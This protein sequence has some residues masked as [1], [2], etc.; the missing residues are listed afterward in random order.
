MRG[1]KFCRRECQSGKQILVSV[2]DLLGNLDV[3]ERVAPRERSLMLILVAVGRDQVRAVRGTV[4][5]NFAL[6]TAADGAD[7]LALRRTE[8]CCFS[9][10]TDRTGHGR[11]PRLARQTRRILPRRLKDQT[12]KRQNCG[13]PWFGRRNESAWHRRAAGENFCRELREGR[14]NDR[15]RRS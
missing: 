6:R 2:D 13:E 3:Q 4:D 11:P 15:P 5:G 9:F 14:R 1:G 7:L 10:L 8:S 12:P